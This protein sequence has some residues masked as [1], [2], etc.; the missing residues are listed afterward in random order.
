M[1]LSPLS[2]RTDN[3]IEFVPCGQCAECLRKRQ[4]DWTIRTLIEW[5]NT[6]VKRRFIPYFVTLTYDDRH[7]SIIDTDT[8]PV[9]VLN[10]KDIHQLWNYLRIAK[11]WHADD[12]FRFFLCGEYGSQRHRPHY[13]LLMFVRD[14][15]FIKDLSDYWYK[16]F[17]PEALNLVSSQRYDFGCIGVYVKKIDISSYT[18][19]DK[20]SRYISK[21][22]SKGSF[23]FTKTPQNRDIYRKFPSRLFCS[24]GYGMQRLDYYQ[25]RLKQITI[26]RSIMRQGK[27]YWNPDYL[28]AAS[29]VLSFNMGTNMKSPDKNF[30]RLLPDVYL[31]KLVPKKSHNETDVEYSENGKLNTRQ[32]V[33][34][35]KPSQRFEVSFLLALSNFQ[36]EVSKSRILR[37]ARNYSHNSSLSEQDVEFSYY[38]GSEERAKQSQSLA[39]S[40][41]YRL[42]VSAW[43]N[44]QNDFQ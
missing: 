17:C 8:E 6:V 42:S 15:Q 14:E 37:T 28:E 12:D 39:I 24:R 19:A 3:G 26:R 4:Q 43:Y 1:C 27:R 35:F 36:D 22:V 9:Y 40:S 30:V 20:V 44:N 23:D 29:N 25:K 16:T 32:R 33:D 34:R 21:Y 31:N 10:Y 38:I 5:E 2:K 7:I 18:S 13:H 11:G 41:K